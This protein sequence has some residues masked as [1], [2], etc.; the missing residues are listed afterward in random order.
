MAATAA[1]GAMEGSENR[2]QRY[3]CGNVGVLEWDENG[4]GLSR[5]CHDT[6]GGGGKGRNDEEGTCANQAA[7]KRRFL[8]CSTGSEKGLHSVWLGDVR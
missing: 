1:T 5:I 4:K 2:E 6:P 8:L 7:V 3:G